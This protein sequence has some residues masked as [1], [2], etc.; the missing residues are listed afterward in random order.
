MNVG[1]LVT[2]DRKVEGVVEMMLD[3]TGTTAGR[4]LPNGCS[5]GTVRCSRPGGAD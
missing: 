4:S 5:R 2:A 1:G 3:A